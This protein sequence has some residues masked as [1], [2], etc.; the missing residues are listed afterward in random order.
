VTSS[1]A[2]QGGVQTVQA[3]YDVVSSGYFTALHMALRAGREFGSQE[4]EA[5]EPV[6]IVNETLAARFTGGAIGQ[7]IKL[8]NE[9]TPRRVV[10]IARDV[11]YNVIT[12]SGLPF[13]YLPFPQI[14]RPD[15][16]V[17]VRTRSPH[18]E[19]I[20]RNAVRA[21]D[22]NVA[23]SGVRTLDDQVAE[24][25]AV[26]R[27]SA[28]IS[29]GAALVAVFLALV[30]VYGVLATSVERRRRELAIRAALGAAPAEIVRRI[31]VEGATLTAIGLTLGLVVSLSSSGLIESLLFEVGP[32]DGAV[33]S[34]VP[35]LLVTASA[36]AWVAP[37]RRAA[38]VDPVAVLRA[39]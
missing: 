17:Y 22:P 11:K 33:Y 8:P 28:L 16:S 34:L 12:E 21:L 38:R 32:R 7:T 6:A 25:S 3:R 1:F 5:S 29:A 37:A 35:L 4:T 2:I 15:M 10:G 26:P 9:K 24:A 36:A 30:G 31:V 27:T 20:I 19:S 39:E 18:A 23:V 14:Y 13:V